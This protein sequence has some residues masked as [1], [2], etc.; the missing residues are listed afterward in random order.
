MEWLW[1]WIFKWA[2]IKY[3]PLFSNMCQNELSCLLM[4]FPCFVVKIFQ[5]FLKPLLESKRERKAWNIHV[6]EKSREFEVC[7]WVPLRKLQVRKSENKC[8]RLWRLLGRNIVTS[9]RIFQK[10]LSSTFMVLHLKCDIYSKLRGPKS[11]N[12][13]IQHCNR[14][15]TC[16]LDLECCNL[17]FKCYE[18]DLQT[19]FTFLSRFLVQKQL[20]AQDQEGSEHCSAVQCSAVWENACPIKLHEMSSKLTRLMT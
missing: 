9:S 11:F 6:L 4:H 16:F 14:V 13:A 8:T 20:L 10:G 7:F 5:H 15:V 18:Y 17:L 3:Q 12:R 1:I 2:L 19:K